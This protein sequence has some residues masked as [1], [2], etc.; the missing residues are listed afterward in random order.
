MRSTFSSISLLLC[1]VP[2][3][4]A[5]AN[6]RY[7]L[8]MF[9]SN[10][11]PKEP[12]YSHTFATFVH[13]RKDPCDRSYQIKS[14]RTIS[15][16]PKSLVVR[17]RALLPEKGANF[18]LHFTLDYVLSSK[19]RVSLWGPLEIEKKLYDEGIDQVRYLESGRVKYKAV[20]SGYRNSRVSN[21]I[22]AVS[23]S[24]GLRAFAC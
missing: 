19:Q 11:I 10:R 15:W 18:D 8:L 2:V 9:G 1:L 7:Y 3:A 13:V 24:T 4:T 21:C 5:S 23:S 6:D 12:N 16:L 14:V 20:D 17:T 22:H